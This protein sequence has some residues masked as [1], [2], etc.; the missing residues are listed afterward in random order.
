MRAA[1]LSVVLI[2]CAHPAAL[3]PTT[4]PP[5]RAYKWVK[6]EDVRQSLV[7]K[8][9]T[10]LA[11][12]FCTAAVGRAATACAMRFAGGR[13]VI[14]IEPGAGAQAAHEAGGHCMGYDHR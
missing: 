14:V 7:T 13:C 11:G 10:D 2:G 6:T 5:A 9:E 8:I 12:D 4:I 3:D 1:L